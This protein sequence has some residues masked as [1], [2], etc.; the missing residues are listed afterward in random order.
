MEHCCVVSNQTAGEATAF[1]VPVDIGSFIRRTTEADD[2]RR[3]VNDDDSENWPLKFSPFSSPL[4]SVTPS[5]ESSR[6]ST[7]VPPTMSTPSTID[8]PSSTETF[9]N[10]L[11]PDV[12]TTPPTTILYQSRKRN[13]KQVGASKR[14]AN[15][16]IKR[17]AEPWK[18]KI[19]SSCSEQH[20]RDVAYLPVHFNA[21]RLPAT[22]PGFIGKRFPVEEGYH[23]LPY[24]IQRGYSVMDWN[25]RYVRL[26]TRAQTLLTKTYRSTQVLHD[27]E[28]RLIVACVAPPDIDGEWQDVQSGVRKAL[29]AAQTKLKFSG[30]LDRRGTFQTIA[31]GISYGGG[32]RVRNMCGSLFIK[33]D[34]LPLSVRECWPITAITARFSRSC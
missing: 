4:S 31:Y 11:S 12:R 14:R 27:E 17:H 24:Y 26:A 8:Q 13:H 19:R 29:K 5:P 23:E 25:A 20:V 33:T 2:A 7:P 34:Y 6:P 16:R 28:G 10:L 21:C 1:A 22:G 3:D 9:A 15:K 30:I 18:Y 32:Q